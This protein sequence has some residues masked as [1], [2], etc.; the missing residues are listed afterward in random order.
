MP[1]VVFDVGFCAQDVG[2]L[3]FRTR[4]DGLVDLELGDGRAVQA[5]SGLLRGVL[6][7][8]RQGEPFGRLHPQRIPLGGCAAMD[9]GSRERDTAASD[10]AILA[11]TDDTKEFTYTENVI[12]FTVSIQGESATVRNE[13]E[14]TISCAAMGPPVRPSVLLQLLGEHHDDPAGPA[15]V[16]EFVDIPVC[17]HTAKRMAPVS[18]GNLQSCVDVVNGEGD[19]VH[20]DLVGTGGTRIDRFWV[21]VLEEFKATVTVWGLQQCNPGVVAIE[22]DRSVGPL[23]TDRIPAD[24]GESEVSEKGDRCLEVA[25]SDANV[26]QFDGHALHVT[27]TDRRDPAGLELAQIASTYV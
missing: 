26:L 24:D 8:G 1:A 9:P 21:D 13:E 10:T 2:E 25:N 6:M 23:A 4:R 15:N 20:T 18:R 19:A 11:S 27:K 16:G 22:S 3:L 17:G 14:L 7:V 5:G 12:S